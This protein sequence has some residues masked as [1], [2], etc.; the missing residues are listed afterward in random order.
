M[1]G[2]ALTVE[3]SSVVP[4]VHGRGETVLVVEDN[5]ALRRIVVRQLGEL[6]YRVLAA[7]NATAGLRLLEQQSIDLLLTDIVMPGGINGRELA[8]RARQRWPGIKVVFTSGFSEAWLS[9]DAGRLSSRAPLLS[10]PYRKEE[11]ANAARE[12]LDRAEVPQ[13]ILRS[14]SNAV[15]D[16]RSG[17]KGSDIA[18]VCQRPRKMVS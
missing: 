2:E 10:K 17:S 8:Q 12:A 9:G 3:E 6:G 18:A 7:E 15:I 11:L 4:L 13:T 16:R 5:T 1:V 14:S